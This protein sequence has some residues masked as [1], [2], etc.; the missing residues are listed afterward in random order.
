MPLLAAMTATATAN[1]PASSAF[2]CSSSNSNVSSR[3]AGRGSQQVLAEAC[4]AMFLGDLQNSYSSGLSLKPAQ[5]L[6]VRCRC[7][8]SQNSTANILMQQL[9]NTLLAYQTQLVVLLSLSLF[10]PAQAAH[11]TAHTHNSNH[12]TKRHVCQPKHHLLLDQLGHVTIVSHQPGAIVSTSG[13]QDANIQRPS[14]G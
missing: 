5:P 11:S 3:A 13:C 10:T 1:A 9:A 6:Q 7:Q 14:G 12:S 8:G 4:A 2:T